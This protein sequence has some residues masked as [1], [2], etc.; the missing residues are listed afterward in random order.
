M[1]KAV[2]PAMS[3]G[4]RP[5]GSTEPV[6]M[7]PF[8]QVQLLKIIVAISACGLF[9]QRTADPVLPCA[10]PLQQRLCPLQV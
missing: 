3:S 10:Q 8:E 2:V 7:C 6:Q 5:K 1:E 9:E 4:L